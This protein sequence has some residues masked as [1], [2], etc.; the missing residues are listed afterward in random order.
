MTYPRDVN[1]G[2]WTMSRTGVAQKGTFFGLVD[3]EKAPQS[4]DGQT[5]T[6]SEIRYQ[7]KL[8]DVADVITNKADSEIHSS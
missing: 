3:L 7:S 5:L 2:N 1:S 6:I 4:F 8:T